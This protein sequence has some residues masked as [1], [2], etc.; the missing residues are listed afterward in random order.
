MEIELCFYIDI[1]ILV[2]IIINMKH[3]IGQQEK[4]QAL[5]RKTAIASTREARESGIHSEVLRRMVAS[6]QLVRES[7]GIYMLTDSDVTENHSL[8]VVA[9]AVPEAVFCLLTAL[10]FH[11]IG[12]QNPPEVWIAL[13]RPAAQVCC[14]GAVRHDTRRTAQ[15]FLRLRTQP[16]PQEHI[17]HAELAAKIVRINF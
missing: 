5:F 1:Y 10:R 6:G 16:L 11:G 9:K 7:R 2:Y 13:R 3:K 14:C 12:T 8:A 4:V 17:P 15:L